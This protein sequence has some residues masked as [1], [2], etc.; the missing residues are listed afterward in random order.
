[1]TR[2][3]LTAGRA[4]ATMRAMRGKRKVLLAAVLAMAV[5][6]ISGCASPSNS[7]TADT[8]AAPPAAER[9]E[10]I[11]QDAYEAA[12]FEFVDCM[13]STGHT[14]SYIRDDYLFDMNV[15]APAVSDG[16]FDT[17][18]S[19]HFRAEDKA[20]QLLNESRSDTQKILRECLIDAGIDPGTTVAEVQLQLEAND[21]NIDTCLGL[22]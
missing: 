4:A 7:Q 12:F 15:L 19:T 18:Y 20:W 21:L 11:T 8:G 17:C 16:S 6:G 1:M 22:D 5:I 3:L 10:D 13:E 9:P 14:V 2:N